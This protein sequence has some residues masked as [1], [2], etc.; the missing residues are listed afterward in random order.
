MQNIFHD[1]GFSNVGVS[2]AIMNV[3]EQQ[4]KGDE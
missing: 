4:H 2:E 1:G 3:I